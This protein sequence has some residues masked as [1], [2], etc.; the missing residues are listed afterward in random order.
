MM[1]FTYKLNEDQDEKLYELARQ[2]RPEPWR[3]VPALAKD[4]VVAAFMDALLDKH[5]VQQRAKAAGGQKKPAPLDW[6][7]I[8]QNWGTGL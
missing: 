4:P 6:K 7:A 3:L 2:M 5:L 1:E 8:K